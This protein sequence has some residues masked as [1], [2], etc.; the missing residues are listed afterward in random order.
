MTDWTRAAALAGVAETPNVTAPLEA[1]EKAFDEL[2]A[3]VAA[4]PSMAVRFAPASEN[5]Q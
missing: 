5:R 2:K 4:P 1:V 3:R